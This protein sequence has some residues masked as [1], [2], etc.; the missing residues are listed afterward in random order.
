MFDKLAEM[1]QNM[2]KKPVAVDPARFADP[3]AIQTEWKPSKG[4]GTSFRTH[5]LVKINA[6]RM[7]FKATL[8]SKLFSCVFLL[9]GV[10]VLT[11]FT[12]SMLSPNADS[13]DSGMIVFLLLGCVFA[14][15]GGGMLYFGTSPVV[16]DKRRGCFWKGRRDPSQ[17]LNK[18]SIKHY[19]ELDNIHALQLISEYCRSNKN[20]Y[21]SFELNLVLNDGNRINVIDHGNKEKIRQDAGI[22]SVFLGKPVWDAI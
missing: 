8:G 19:A 22:L 3:V 5:K 18:K 14:G 20:S 6:D 12:V 1:I 21:Y 2:A 16:F 13:L 10:A 4:G 15:I 9:V 7:E 11:G 17:L